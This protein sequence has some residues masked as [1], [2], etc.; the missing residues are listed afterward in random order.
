MTGSPASVSARSRRSRPRGT[1]AVRTAKVDLPFAASDG[2]TTGPP[3]SI[4]QSMCTGKRSG[5]R[6]IRTAALLGAI[7]AQEYLKEQKNRC[8][9]GIYL[10]AAAYRNRIYASI[11]A[12]LL[13]FLALAPVSATYSGG[14]FEKPRS[15]VSGTCGR[16][17]LRGARV[18]P[19]YRR[20]YP[21][22]LRHA[23][24][25]ASVGLVAC[26]GS[27]PRPPPAAVALVVGAWRPGWNGGK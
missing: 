5:A 15:C 3:A 25:P 23:R 26:A 20:R 9:T 27:L 13:P 16:P 17:S 2:V 6:R 14:R 18:P 21:R 11:C 22:P 19:T 7:G 24:R 12:D 10:C 1:D 8:F 4:G